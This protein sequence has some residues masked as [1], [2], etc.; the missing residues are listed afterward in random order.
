MNKLSITSKKLPIVIC[1]VVIIFVGIIGMLVSYI[2]K[3][4]PDIGLRWGIDFTGGTVFNFSVKR[5]VSPEDLK[6]VENIVK[7]VTGETPSLVQKTT[8]SAVDTSV[9]NS[10]DIIIVKCNTD[11]NEDRREILSL[12][13]KEFSLPFSN[14]G[15][16]DEN[17]DASKIEWLL[18]SDSVGP[19]AAADLLKSAFLATSIAALLMLVYISLRFDLY[20][21]IAAVVALLHDVSMMIIFNLIFGIQ[22][23]LPFIAAVLTIL[24][25]SINATIV[26]FDRIR[27]NNNQMFEKPFDLIVEKSIRQ[28]M[29]RSIFTSLTTLFTVLILFILSVPSIR[30]FS[31][32][33][34]I[35]IIAG[36]YSSV[37]I[38]G[39]VWLILKER[40]EK[41]S[42]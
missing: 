21:G 41:K 9:L 16:S 34:I 5:D 7:Q 39:N 15:N 25:Y 1:A 26:I 33:I 8:V 10:T 19:A 22:I 12:I 36:F 28:T 32:P 24:G 37:C 30:E 14:E 20:S 2:F 40:K 3:D 13:A 23:N 6:T 31:F 27:E 11:K 38:S 29:R 42:S 18:S 17:V 4:N 35:G